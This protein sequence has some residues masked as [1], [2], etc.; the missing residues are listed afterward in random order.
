MATSVKKIG[1]TPERKWQK[2]AKKP[3]IVS[4]KPGIVYLSKRINCCVFTIIGAYADVKVQ[5]KS[6]A[7]VSAAPSFFGHTGMV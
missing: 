4:S 7:Y 3:R 2:V 6:M 1:L 5:C